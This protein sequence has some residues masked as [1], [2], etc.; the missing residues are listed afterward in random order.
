MYA[1]KVSFRTLSMFDFPFDPL[2]S[3]VVCHAIYF[4]LARY[5]LITRSDLCP[6]YVTITIAGII[7]Q[8]YNVLCVSGPFG[9]HYAEIYL[10]SIDF[11]SISYVGL[12]SLYRLYT[13]VFAAPRYMV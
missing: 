10:D 3:V 2:V 12:T 5:T 9:I 4:D 13:D 1:V 7:C 11:V 6:S 8:H